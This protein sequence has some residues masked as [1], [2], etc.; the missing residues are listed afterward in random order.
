MINSFH[1]LKRSFVLLDFS[2]RAYHSIAALI[3]LLTFVI[4]LVEKFPEKQQF[5]KN[6]ETLGNCFNS[7]EDVVSFSLGFNKVISP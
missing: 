5:L 7:L 3:F 1:F 6:K 2:Q 4:F